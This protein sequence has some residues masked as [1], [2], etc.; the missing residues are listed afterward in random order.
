MLEVAHMAVHVGQM[1]S[2]EA[3]RFCF[4]A[5]TANPARIMGLEGY[6]LEPGCNAD[7]VLLQAADPIEAIRLKATRLAVVRRGALLAQSAPRLARLS[8]AA[9]SGHARSGSLR[10]V[11]GARL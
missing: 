10:A 1:T 5:V 9:A 7:F 4:D 3:M 8:H 6:G 2:R 11:T